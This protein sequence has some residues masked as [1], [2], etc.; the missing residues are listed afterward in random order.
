PWRQTSDPYSIWVSEVMLQ[1]TQVS[2]VIPYYERFLSQF[3]NLKSL[4]QAK[5]ESVLALWAGLGYYSR[6][7]NL[8]QGA[9]FLME[10]HQ[11]KFPQSREELL[12]VPGIGPYTAGAVLSIAFNLNIPLVDG[13]VE[14]VFSRYFGFNKPSD[15]TEA[16][17]FF[18]EKS[19]AL[20]LKCASARILNQGLMELGSLVCTKSA[21]QCQRCPLKESCVALKN[22]CVDRLPFKKRKTQYLN[23]TQLK[24]LCEK[25][26]KIW[27]RQNSEK[28]WWSGLW[29]FP[30]TNLKA[31]KKWIPEVE[32]WAKELKATSWKDLSR[33]KHTV[34]HHRLDIVPIHFK[35]KKAPSK[36]GKWV[37]VKE[38][39][40]LPVSALVK[41]IILQDF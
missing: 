26:G 12:K 34:T 30:T 23:L 18:W 39:P 3:P 2:T 9:K 15:S 7:R 37:P 35:V 4:A 13:N 32:R 16:K 38:I 36:G 20:V 19:E 24:F 21:P 41:K 22:D 6:A 31:P 1:Q 27:L 5:E 40:A 8:H 29:D 10:M 25:D 11:G 14:R 17:H 33:Q 28:E